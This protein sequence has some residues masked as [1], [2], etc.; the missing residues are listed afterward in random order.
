MMNYEPPAVIQVDA[1][2]CTFACTSFGG[3]FG[4]QQTSFLDRD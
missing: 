4:A 3:Y 1:T 2:N